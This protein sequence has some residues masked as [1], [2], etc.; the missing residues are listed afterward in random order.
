MAKQYS[1]EEVKKHND[2]QGAW[3]IIHNNV[4]DV[5]AFLNEVRLYT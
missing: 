4:Y 1:C 3:I 2:N 5:T